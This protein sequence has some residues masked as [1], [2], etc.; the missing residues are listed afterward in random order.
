M[1]NSREIKDIILSD[2]Y[3]NF[4]GV[5]ISRDTKSK[6]MWNTIQGGGVYSTSTGGQITGFGA[7][8]MKPGFHGCIIIDDAQKPIDVYSEV[9]RKDTNERFNSTIKSRMNNPSQ[10][11]IIV[12]GQRLHQ[13]DLSGYLLSGKSEFQFEHLN[14]PAINED[15]PGENDQRKVGKPL[16]PKKHNV[17]QLKAMKKKDIKTYTEQ[18]QQRPAPMEGLVI[19]RK[20]IKRFN[21]WPKEF[22]LGVYYSVDM[23]AKE[24]GGSNACL[25]KY[26]V[27]S[28]KIYLLD[29]SVGQWSFP[30]ARIHFRDFVKND[31]QG[32]LIEAKANGHALI[33][34]I[35]EEYH[36]V[37]PIQVDVNKEYRL[38][39][40]S[41]LYLGG[42]VWYPD[43]SLAPWA[44]EHLTEVI[45]FPNTK[46]N[47]RVDAET[48]MLKFYQTHIRSGG[49]LDI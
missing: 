4:W 31:Y 15:G 5:A 41:M 3:Q 33:A 9:K 19:K 8:S 27:C 37:I 40:V 18:Y 34:S 43:D 35:E 36:S 45:S 1:D 47:D 42:N 32:I 49:Y 11:P 46:F 24:S 30:Q 38:N 21:V 28:T 16:W 25:S 39:E 23:N 48:Q 17:V 29:Q 6:K 44:E 12:I 7:G 26:G 14:L 13:D 2:C 20:W 10:T 22:D